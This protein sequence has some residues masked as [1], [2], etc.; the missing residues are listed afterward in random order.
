MLKGDCAVTFLDLSF[1]YILSAVP[2]EERKDIQQRLH[3]HLL[4]PKHQSLFRHDF[5][6]SDPSA[7]KLPIINLIRN[8]SE[9]LSSK[10]DRSEFPTPPFLI[11]MSYEY[12]VSA[13]GP[14]SFLGIFPEEVI[15][16]F[17]EA[18]GPHNSLRILN[19]DFGS[20]HSGN[21]I[22]SH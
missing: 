2:F 22:A 13:P 4:E 8:G 17:R 9:S 6:Q 5:A 7:L 1:D 11:C 18:D 16:I 12:L 19:A 20:L 10:V 3:V 15:Q 21:Y 14:T